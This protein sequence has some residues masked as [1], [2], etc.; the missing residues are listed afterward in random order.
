MN[1][2]GRPPKKLGHVDKLEGEASSKERLK[3]ILKTLSGLR[4]LKS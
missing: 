2:R 1:K 3:V 4:R